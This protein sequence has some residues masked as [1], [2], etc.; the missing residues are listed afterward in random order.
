MS[1]V[2]TS[3]G[4]KG[5][6]SSET[7]EPAES[8]TIEALA[9]QLE[10]LKLDQESLR[11]TVE[12]DGSFRDSLRKIV[13]LPMP[14]RYAG[15]P[16]KLDAWVVQLSNYISYNE[17]RFE[18]EQSKTIFG[19]SLLDDVAAKWYEPHAKRHIEFEGLRA[20]EEKTLNQCRKEWRDKYPET[21]AMFA[22]F[23]NFTQSITEEFG[24][25]DAE[26]RAETR[27]MNLVQ[28]TSVIEYAAQFRVEAAKT[29]LGQEALVM[30]FWKGLKK[31]VTDELYKQDR[32][33]ELRQLIMLAVRTDNRYFDYQREVGRT[34]E[35]VP[36]KGK[37]PR[38][39][40]NR[41][42]EKKTPEPT[43]STAFGHH[44]G[45]MDI[46][47]LQKK[48]GKPQKDVSKVKCFNCDKMGHYS[49][50]CKEKKRVGWKPLPEPKTVRFL[51]GQ[52]VIRMVVVDEDEPD[53]D[54]EV[55]E[56]DDLAQQL[57]HLDLGTLDKEKGI[58]RSKPSG[59]FE[60]EVVPGMVIQGREHLSNEP[61]RTLSDRELGE[62]SR[63]TLH[64]LMEKAP[65]AAELMEHAHWLRQ[66]EETEPGTLGHLPKYKEG[67]TDPEEE[68]SLEN[69]IHRVGAAK[70]PHSKW[71]PTQKELEKMKDRYDALV[72]LVWKKRQIKDDAREDELVKTGVAI[73]E[74]L[75]EANIL[76]RG[77]EEADIELEPISRRYP[78][79]WEEIRDNRRQMD[80]RTALMDQDAYSH[81]ADAAG[82]CLNHPQHDEIAWFS[83]LYDQCLLPHHLSP[84][85]QH[86]HWPTREQRIPRTIAYE[87]LDP[88]DYKVTLW[89]STVHIAPRTPAECWWGMG[90]LH[91]ASVTCALHRYPKLVDWHAKKEAQE[92]KRLRNEKE[93][94]ERMVRARYQRSEFRSMAKIEPFDVSWTLSR[95][96]Q[97]TRH[98]TLRLHSEHPA[99]R[100][101]K[102]S[103]PSS[104]AGSQ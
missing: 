11:G 33:G 19:G 29:H 23:E 79:D 52:A 46:G 7:V 67:T 104:R 18:D 72:R 1:T 74:M 12:D 40:G 95:D 103:R 43:P 6:E 62:Q 53:E 30:L 71:G 101:G 84:K 61:Q 26:R 28:K 51:E 24:E 4:K 97:G 44:P 25:L 59:S 99:K 78:E 27:L 76:A 68:G 86:N 96:A 37:K 64:R 41:D 63:R 100:L 75:K 87:H 91:C 49:R 48:R 73:R 3:S 94:R 60:V 98:G 32:P 45:P 21:V 69:R 22:A 17:S 83:C 55:D 35:Y 47:V 70:V 39:N 5:K 34:R 65:R 85:I 16:A 9:E 90:I 54:D 15:S 10:K 13:K 2:A 8:P 36:A 42:P 38:A 31:H 58:L 93:Q 20:T 50:D 56:V 89:G 81:K 14:V 80:A 66:N 88:E 82:I 57:Q 102:G 77:L 92:A